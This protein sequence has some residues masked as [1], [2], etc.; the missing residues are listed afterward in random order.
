[1]SLSKSDGNVAG[2][3][4]AALGRAFMRTKSALKRGTL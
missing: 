2:F 4:A 1:M 3:H